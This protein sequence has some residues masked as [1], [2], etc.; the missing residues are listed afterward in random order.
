MTVESEQNSDFIEFD[1]HTLIVDWSKATTYDSGRYYITVAATDDKAWYGAI[2][3][4]LTLD[5]AC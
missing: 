3:F 1:S 2:S 4:L 5:V